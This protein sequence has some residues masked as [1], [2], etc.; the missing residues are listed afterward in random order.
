VSGYL[1]F[2]NFARMHQALPV[3][4]RRCSTGDLRRR[5]RPNLSAH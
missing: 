4:L 1:I 5:T 3:R 2:Y